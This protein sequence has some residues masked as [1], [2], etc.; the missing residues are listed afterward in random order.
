[1]VEFF[2]IHR[3]DQLSK[4]RRL[5]LCHSISRATESELHCVFPFNCWR[6]YTSCQL[7]YHPAVRTLQF[8]LQLLDVL[9]AYLRRRARA[10]AARRGFTPIMREPVRVEGEEAWYRWQGQSPFAQS[11]L[12]KC[13]ADAEQAVL[14]VVPDDDS[15]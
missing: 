7:R 9:D 1:V 14:K 2:W 5:G 11:D 8:L 6:D 4:S 12:K 10:K 15:V 3:D 13:N